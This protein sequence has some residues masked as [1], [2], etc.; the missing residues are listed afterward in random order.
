MEKNKIITGYLSSNSYF[1]IYLEKDDNN[2][3]ILIN[4]FKNRKFIKKGLEYNI[5][6]PLNHLIKLEPGF[7]AEVKIINENKI[8]LLNNKNPTGIIRGNNIKIKSNNDAM[9][10]FYLDTNL[11][12][13]KLDIKKNESIE[14]IIKDPS[15]YFWIDFGFENFE[16]SLNYYN[17]FINWDYN[18]YINSYF[19]EN[20]YEN[21]KTELVKGENLYIYYNDYENTEDNFQI[22]Y[23]NNKNIYQKNKY[24][25]Y[26]IKH[27]EQQKQ[28]YL[29]INHINKEKIKYQVHFCKLEPN[30]INVNIFT[31]KKNLSIYF[32]DNMAEA[33]LNIESTL[34][35]LNFSANNDF[36][37]TY[38]FIDYYDIFRQNYTDWFKERIELTNLTINELKFKNENNR[39]N[40]IVSINFN[41]NY[42]NSITKYFIIISNENNNINNFD[43]F[44]IL[45]NPCNIVEK[46]INEN[47]KVIIEEIY[48]I[49]EN[50]FINIDINISDI[51]YENN[52]LFVVNIISQELKFDKK[53]NFYKAEIFRKNNIKQSVK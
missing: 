11:R 8:I 4:N 47:N 18:T 50:E 7:N 28:K 15:R 13:I 49:G 19:F 34:S 38:S 27:D 25:L 48:D 53:I 1:D 40:N 41:P 31:Y 2:T 32:D 39:L 14:I 10:Y 45:N 23:I 9:I 16:L 17:Q 26:L 29:Y 42:K 5:K 20:F 35:R 24:N 3:D 52:D 21:L 37:L 33:E 43:D 36:I 30:F 6:F 51:F 12:Q 22:N 46:L 44:S